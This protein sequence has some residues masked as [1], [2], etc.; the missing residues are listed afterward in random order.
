MRFLSWVVALALLATLG[1]SLAFSSPGVRRSCLGRA[2]TTFGSKTSS[3]RLF[4][5]NFLLNRAQ[6]TTNLFSSNRAGL[7]KNGNRSTNG[8]VTDPSSTLTLL[9]PTAEDMEEIGSLLATVLLEEDPASA[10]GTVIFL[11]GDLG[12]GKRAV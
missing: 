3:R 6:P 12:A 1:M 11:E 8:T 2:S 9:V 4:P 7:S 10:C 5:N